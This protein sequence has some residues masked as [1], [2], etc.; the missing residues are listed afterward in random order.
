MI[1]AENESCPLFV[2]VV[3]VIVVEHMHVPLRQV[4]VKWLEENGF[5]FFK[6]IYLSLA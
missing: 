2:V 5:L 3:E 1:Q 4:L 6:N